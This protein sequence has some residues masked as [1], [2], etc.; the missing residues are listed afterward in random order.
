MRTITLIRWFSD[1]KDSASPP[2]D[3]AM[4]W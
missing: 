3:A 2:P 1:R 4:L